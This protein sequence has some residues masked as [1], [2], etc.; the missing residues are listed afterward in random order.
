MIAGRAERPAADEAAPASDGLCIFDEHVAQI[1]HWRLQLPDWKRTWSAETYR[2]FGL[3]PAADLPAVDF[4]LEHYHP[5][6][7][8]RVREAVLTAVRARRDWAFEARIIRPNGE[9]RNVLIRGIC[10]GDGGTIGSLFGVIIDVTEHR[11]TERRARESEGLFKLFVDSITNAAICLIDP[12]GTITHWNSGARRIEGYAA[13]EIVGKHFSC[14]YTTCDRQD[15]RPGSA[16]RHAER[17]GHS[18]TECWAVRKD[19]SLFWANITLQALRDSTGALVGFAKITRDLSENRKAELDLRESEARYRLL[20]EN[21]TDLVIQ[22][23]L[24]STRR[25]VSPAARSLLGYAPEELVGTK[26]FDVLHPEDQEPFQWFLDSLPDLDRERA[27]TRQRYRH[28]DG[29]YVWAETT[30]SLIKDQVTGMATGYVASIRDISARHAS[31][32]RAKYL[33]RHD[34]LTDLPNRMCFHERMEAVL[35]RLKALG[36]KSALLWA[37]LNRFKCINDT[38]GH[39]VGD[40]LLRKVAARLRDVVP[41]EDIVARIGGDEFA[42]LQHDCQSRHNIASLARR[43]IAAINEP[44]EVSGLSLSVGAKI[45]ISV[46]PDDGEDTDLLFRAAD[47]ALYRARDVAQSKF[48]FYEPAMDDAAQRRLQMELDLKDAVANEEF[49]LEYQPV[50]DVA[51]GQIVGC[52]ALL[53]WRHRTKGVVP[54]ADFIPIAEESGLIVPLGAWVLR[55]AC[56]DAATWSNQD[57]QIAVN[58]ST[59]QLRRPGLEATILAALDASGL[60]PWRLVLEITESVL[61][62]ESDAVLALLHRL[63]K[64]G[65]EISLDDFGTGYSSL[66]YLHR[67]PFDK[68]KIDRCFVQA[69]GEHGAFTIVQLIAEL[70]ERLG[71]TIIAEGIETREQLDRVRQVGCRQYQGYLFSRST[72]A[73]DVGHMLRPSRITTAA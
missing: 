45:G 66:S 35:V 51:S 17:S 72:S 3:D 58:V 56:L 32:E 9:T 6:D 41:S 37:D 60:Q 7:R 15:G 63:R 46:M 64:V 57:V 65:V 24:D 61:I 19:G 31:E 8:E 26:A 43:I 73:M 1:G 54:P 47:L 42:I 70:G 44:I 68:L 28:K 38:F 25:Y 12:A 67:F 48:C 40:E 59:C 10:D 53:R 33:A 20:A 5:D 71:M 16:L 18:E 55:Q 21:T 36:G 2:I 34:S 39:P 13:E 14:F 49:R 52:E 22:A 29:H 4:D 23:D 30:Y 69:M 11:K 50:V 27:I 62:Q